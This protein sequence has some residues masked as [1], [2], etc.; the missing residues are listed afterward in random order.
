MTTTAA[1]AAQPM[2]ELLEQGHARPLLEGYFPVPVKLNGRWWHVPTQPPPG[3]DP[4]AFV[5]APAATADEY[6]RLAARRCAADNAA[7]RCS[8]I[9]PP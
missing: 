3:V 9:A 2:Q 7:H 6:A 8:S 4:D 1:I 5:P